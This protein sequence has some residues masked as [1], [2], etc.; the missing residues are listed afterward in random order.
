METATTLDPVQDELRKM[1]S[2]GDETEKIL[3]FLL[4]AGIDPQ[5]ASEMIIRERGAHLKKRRQRGFILG[6]AGS[7][8]LLIGFLLTVIFFHSGVNFHFVMYGLTSVGA[9]LLM[10]GLV[11]VIGW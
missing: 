5:S 3:N 7:A 10:A 11:E 8:M 6:A 9:I 4:N 1:I 2:K